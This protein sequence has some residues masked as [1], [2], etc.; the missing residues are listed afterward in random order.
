MAAP[1]DGFEQYFV[2]KLWEWIPE[3]YRYEDGTAASPN[4]LR[5]LIELLGPS[6]AAARRSVDRLWEDQFA[7]F[8]DD[9]ALPYIGDLIGTRLINPLNRRGQRAD[10]ARTIYYRRR[11]GTLTVLELLARDI[12]GW[13]GVVVEAFRRLGRTPHRLDQPLVGS[14]AAPFGLVTDTPPG[15]FADLRRPRGGDLV[16]GPFDEYSHTADVRQLRGYKGRYNIPKLN[17][18]LFRR[19][20]FAIRFATPVDLGSGRFTLDPSGRDIDLFRP[21]QHNDDECIRPAEWQ[22]AAPLPCRLLAEAR[23]RLALS[24]IPAALQATLAGLVGLLFESEARLRETLATLLAPA[25]FDNAIYQ[26]LA[27]AITSDSPKFNLLPE[28][29]AA[30][31][32]A[33]PLRS[34]LAVSI[35][36][37]NLAPVIGREFIIPANL[38]VW[39][40]NLT[41]DAGR[42]AALDP[43]RGR[44]SLLRALQPGTH[45][46]VPLY[47]VGLF[48][49]LGASTYSRR[50]TIVRSGVNDLPDGGGANPGPVTGFALPVTGVQQFTTSKTYQPDSPPAGVLVDVEQL[51]LQAAD[52]ERPY[53]RFT[54]ATNGTRWTFRAK[55]KPPNP[56]PNDP[57]QR[58]VLILDGLWLG[59]EPAN[60]APQAVAGETVPA[61][62]VP[63][64]I[65]IEGVF[66]QVIVRHCTI[67]PGGEQAR[68]V[69]TSVTPIPV[70]QLE[71]DGQVEEL[72]IQQSIVGPI[73][74][75]VSAVDPCSGA[76]FVIRDSIVQS[77][78]PSVPA[79]ETRIAALDIQ[80]STVFGSVRVNR[81]EASETLI[82]GLVDV[83]DNQHGCFRFSAANAGSSL[84]QQFESHLLTPTVPNHIFLSRRFG[85]SAF[86]E[87]SETAPEAI[88][89]GAENR[90]EIGVWSGLLSPIKLD[91]LTSK[92]FEFMPLGLI[93]QFINE[94]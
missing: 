19:L 40:A 9:W 61:T 8:A 30:G 75:V 89:R 36:P 1:R 10:I 77:I 50:D 28:P 15:G 74:E 57:A 56:D 7:E 68:T 67:D 91:D 47:H 65:A 49:P 41:F 52:P 24:D 11:K 55:P 4:V 90:S 16:D 45:L 27:A 72:V 48:G 33:A 64:V 71:I 35:G 42:L 53:I 76:K 34:A 73:Q 29:P 69:A 21:S 60:L 93:A 20:P 38:S 12:A 79:I 54:P 82:Q 39:G 46:F 5:S 92:T 6:L 32:S 23:Y 88:R 2:E 87:L 83:I 44:L 43:Q 25:A 37:D 86:A 51:T 14:G 84:P 26:I 70:V 13:D 78:D 63:T 18:H 66:D 81:L 62:P 94:T 59:L 85:D 31:A 58:R 17:F 80:R 3:V 22:L